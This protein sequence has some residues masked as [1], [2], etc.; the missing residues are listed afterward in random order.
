HAEDSNVE[1][2][3]ETRT[4]ILK[5]GEVTH[6]GLRKYSDALHIVAEEGA[7]LPKS[8]HEL[9]YDMNV[10]SIDLSKADSSNVIDMCNMFSDCKKLISIDMSGLDTS[11]VT[12]M[13][14]MFLDCYSLESI[15]LSNFDTSN[16]SSMLAMF[17]NC[18]ALKSLDLSSFNTS[19]SMWRMF[20]HCR[21]LTYLNI[22]N[23]TFTEEQDTT[24]MFMD[25]PEEIIPDSYKDIHGYLAGDANCDG[26][27]KMNDVVLIMQSISNPDQYAVDGT[28]DKRITKIGIINADVSDYTGLTPMDAQLIQQY[29]LGLEEK[30]YLIW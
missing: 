29:L 28:S 26:N 8:C 4:L 15:D 6:Y 3:E 20:G 13:S 21:S 9:F 14:G 23:F 7:I 25:C 19:H 12:S 17:Y 30:L 5:A 16:V 2:D 24:N 11:N 1:Y 10:I 22:N 18:W 27:V